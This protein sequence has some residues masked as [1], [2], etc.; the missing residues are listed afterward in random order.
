[1]GYF[2]LPIILVGV[3]H[4]VPETHELAEMCHTDA[5]VAIVVVTVSVLVYVVVII[6]SEL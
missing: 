2:V 6:R 5:I 3:P 4:V 1:M